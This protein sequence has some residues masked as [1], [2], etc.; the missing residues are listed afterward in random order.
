MGNTFTQATDC[1][2]KKKVHFMELVAQKL[3]KKSFWFSKPQISRFLKEAFKTKE[4]F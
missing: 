2:E 1:T 4:Y 3:Y